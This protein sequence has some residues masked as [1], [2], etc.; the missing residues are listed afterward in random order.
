M[1][2]RD[3]DLAS[4]LEASE[5]QAAIAGVQRS[6]ERAGCQ[7]CEGCGELIPPERRQAAPFATRCLPCQA[8]HEQL[9]RISPRSRFCRL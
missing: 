6:L 5:R 3:F 2:E 9:L 4:A 1:N 7:E 8:G